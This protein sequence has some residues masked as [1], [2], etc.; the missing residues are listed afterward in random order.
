MKQQVHMIGNNNLLRL[1]QPFL[2]SYI[3]LMRLLFFLILTSFQFIAP[4]KSNAEV[5]SHK[6]TEN[7]SKPSKTE[8]KAYA[9]DTRSSADITPVTSLRT[10][11]SQ[12]RYNPFV[13]YFNN[14]DL[15]D[16]LI[17]YRKNTVFTGSFSYFKPIG[18]L[19]IFPQHYF[20]WSFPLK[21]LR[22]MS[23]SHLFP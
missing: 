17:R 21:L 6:P 23:N 16:K 5:I 19:L 3:C 4:L 14:A 1:K 15:L 11:N 9:F 12:C 10:S 13:K 18:L 8:L 22:H 7:I 20:W 2:I